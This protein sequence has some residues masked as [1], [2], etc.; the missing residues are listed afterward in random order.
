MGNESS[1]ITET[2]QTIQWECYL[3]KHIRLE[4][5]A[6]FWTLETYNTL[7]ELTSRQPS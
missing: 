2:S 3:Y 1:T 6:T 7:D 5:I 4:N